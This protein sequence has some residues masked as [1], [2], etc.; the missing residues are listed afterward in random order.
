MG[1]PRPRELRQLSHG[2]MQMGGFQNEE[3]SLLSRD[4]GES[5]GLSCFSYFRKDFR[6]CLLRAVGSRRPRCRLTA[7]ASLMK[8]PSH[9]GSTVLG[10]L[11]HLRGY[12]RGVNTAA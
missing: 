9:R 10:L 7:V 5:D 6:L 12:S 1:M 2:G 3:S 11:V 8:S 4:F